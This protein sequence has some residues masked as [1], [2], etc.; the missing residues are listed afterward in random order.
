VSND[1]DTVSGFMADLSVR[2]PERPALIDVAGGATSYASLDQRVARLVATLGNPARGDRMAV[3]M[4]NGP[5]MSVALLAVMSVC[6]AVPFNPAYT[7]A[8]LE[9]YF[10][11][12]RITSLLVGGD[13]SWTARTVARKLS[14]P[15]MEF[16]T[17]HALP[18]IPSLT[19]PDDIAIILLTSG[20]TGRSKLVPLTHRNLTV[21][22][23]NVA[24]SMG[25]STDDRVLSMWEQYHVGGVVDL[26]LAPLSAG[27]SIVCAGGFNADLALEL[28]GRLKPTWFQGVPTTVRAL[29]HR[30]RELRPDW[31]E[32]SL[33]LLRSVA[34]ALPPEW[35]DDLED[36]FGVPVIQTFGMTEAAPLITS[37]RLPPA[38]RKP[39]ST[40]LPCGTTITI[41]DAWGTQLPQGATGEVA[42][43]GANVF[44]GYLDDAEANAAAFR[45]GW[46]LTGDLGYIDPDG[47]LF[48]AGRTKDLINR[49]GEKISPREVEEVLLSHPSIE[50]A[51]VF[52]VP[53][54]TLGEDLGAAVVLRDGKV[55]TTTDIEAFAAG[56]LA[57]FKVPHR[58]L[59]VPDLPKSSVGKVLRSEV[60]ALYAEQ[61]RRTDRTEPGNG[62]ERA[63]EQ[64]WADEL[65][66][67]SVGV[68]APF[69]EL[70]G[71]SLSSVR[72]LMAA[73]GLLGLTMPEDAA[74]HFTTVRAMAGYLVELGCATE[75]PFHGKAGDVDEA[76]LQATARLQ[77]HPLDLQ[78]LSRARIG[79]EFQT[80]RH[81]AENVAT[82]AELRTMFAQ[83]WLTLRAAVLR[84]VE[85]YHLA[86]ARDPSKR[87]LLRSMLSASDPDAWDRQPLGDNA[88]LYSQ[89]AVPSSDKTLVVGFSG[90]AMRLMTPTFGIL[91]AL[92]PDTADL[93][94]LR[95]P[96]RQH[97]I[98]G[99]PGLGS[100]IEATARWVGSFAVS[101]GYRR[102]VALGS[103]AG[104]TPAIC[105]ALLNAWP[106][107][108]AVGSDQP[109][110]HLHLRQLIETCAPLLPGAGTE[111]LLAY[112]GQRE[113]DVLGATEI[114]ALL[115]SARQM[116]DHR[117]SEHALLYLLQQRGELREFF[118]RHL[119]N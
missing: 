111:V 97:Y 50:Q 88:D 84:P 64:I 26:L 27:G 96:T 12:A 25:L 102:V 45:Q 89:P 68:E 40:G 59:I 35:M 4:P 65:D 7:E 81:A 73:E 47:E 52:G 6:V 95:D 108:L 92:P 31:H 11:Q 69:V 46:F 83:P 21:G 44:S 17:A 114:N 71:D 104:G 36:C 43:R 117:F 91:C 85:T 22:A 19:K 9:A 99:V 67:G 10:A 78:M 28:L 29:Y 79:R 55:A 39:N 49:G 113:R 60:A 13:K 101:R 54:P 94:L 30:A 62:L 87:L 51:A 20:T 98:S 118:T 33:R 107:V 112:S 66:V 106:R 48:L 34:A 80:A 14:I 100:T 90:R 75:P 77:G 53:H 74:R 1:L 63:L 119:L 61:V 105:A 18:P 8:E 93:L 103:S 23:R 76:I 42:V 109:S 38:V 58:Y 15:I 70:G 2:H 37:T 3:V 56:R 5:D 57:H 24:G 86:R 72:I 115:P 32:T 41:I 82:P 16:G 116:P 110:L